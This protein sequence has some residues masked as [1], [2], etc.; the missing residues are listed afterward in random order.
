MCGPEY[1]SL[2]DTIDK[3][4]ELVAKIEAEP[5]PSEEQIGKVCRILSTVRKC[6]VNGI[7][8]GHRDTHDRP[9]IRQYANQIAA[10]LCGE[11]EQKKQENKAI[12]F[13]VWT[14][15]K[16]SDTFVEYIDTT[17][18]N[19]YDSSGKMILR[20][21]H[22]GDSIM[23][24][25]SCDAC[26]L[27]PGEPEVVTQAKLRERWKAPAKDGSTPIDTPCW[28]GGW[29]PRYYAGMKNGRH[30]VWELGNTSFTA[31]IA[32][33]PDIIVLADPNDLKAK[34]PAGFVPEVQ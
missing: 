10:I 14:R 20:S 17:T 28:I 9:W 30:A 3:M 2:R 33:C 1:I 8:I 16:V 24:W 5:K 21:Y 29:R 23:V 18:W 12:T 15:H 19:E 7:D 25:L 27:L 4:K 22:G 11:E 26:E 32:F 34:P 6:D 13:P 31:T